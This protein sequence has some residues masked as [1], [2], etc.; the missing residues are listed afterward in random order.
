[1]LKF[2]PISISVVTVDDTALLKELMGHKKDTHETYGN[3]SWDYKCEVLDSTFSG[4]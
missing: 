2:H 1:M 3:Y 4:D